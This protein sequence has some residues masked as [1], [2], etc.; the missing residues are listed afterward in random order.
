MRSYFLFP[1]LLVI[2][3]K[4]QPQ[5]YN[6]FIYRWLLDF[7]SALHNDEAVRVDAKGAATY[8]NISILINNVNKS[9]I[10]T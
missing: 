10:V 9:Y 3:I 1:E 4:L 5:A 8:K 6:S 7:S 2:E